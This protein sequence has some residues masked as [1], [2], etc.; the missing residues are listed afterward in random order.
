M[1]GLFSRGIWLELSVAP[2]LVCLRSAVILQLERLRPS[3]R[4]VDCVRKAIVL[5]NLSRFRALLVSTCLYVCH[6][7]MTTG[8]PV[9][10]SKRD[11]PRLEY[12]NIHYARIARRYYTI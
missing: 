9:V 1:F 11:Q 2:L 8:P 12:Q 4:C 3:F 5:F 7:E 6:R 10:R